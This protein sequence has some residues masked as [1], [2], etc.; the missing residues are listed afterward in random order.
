V[1]AVAYMEA[2]DQD[3]LL[4][5]IDLFSRCGITNVDVGFRHE[6]VAITEADWYCAAT[7]AGAR[8]VADHHKGA[9]EACEALARQLLNGSGCIHCRRV[10]SLSAPRELEQVCCWRR[11]GE[12]WVPG[13]NPVEPEPDA[14][15]QFLARTKKRR[16]R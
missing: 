4:A 13:C 1:N 11:Q 9:V 6:N 15:Q 3:A 2:T 16:R 12:R 8:I 14:A 5:A 7:F 10:L